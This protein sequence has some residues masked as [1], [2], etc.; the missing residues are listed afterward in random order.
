VAGE[1]FLADRWQWSRGKVSRFLAHL[2]SAAVAMVKTSNPVPQ[3]RGQTGPQKSTAQR[4]LCRII[5]VLNYDLYQST[6]NET[7]PQIEDETGPQAGHKQD[8]RQTGLK[9]FKKLKTS[10]NAS[11]RSQ[12]SV[13]ITTPRQTAEQAMKQAGS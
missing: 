11:K 8:H 7:G 3:K 2:E 13:P 10:G 9:K 1:R 5:T 12:G 6:D 4:N